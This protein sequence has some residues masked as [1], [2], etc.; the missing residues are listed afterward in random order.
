MDQ[1]ELGQLDLYKISSTLDLNPCNFG[2]LSLV[3]ISDGEKIYHL[4]GFFSALN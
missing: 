3:P 2:F 1:M 4:P